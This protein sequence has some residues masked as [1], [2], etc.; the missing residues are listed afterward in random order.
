M[1]NGILPLQGTEEAAIRKH[2]EAAWPAKPPKEGKASL[3]WDT[4]SGASL[5]Y[6]R[7]LLL[8]PVRR[9]CSSLGFICRWR[10]R[11][12][13]VRVRDPAFYVRSCPV[14]WRGVTFYFPSPSAVASATRRTAAHA[15]SK[16]VAREERTSPCRRGKGRKEAFCL[17]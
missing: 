8:L 3:N 5:L 4:T 10:L 16:P 9:S 11:I 6:P 15:Q 17:W 14:V 1:H 7:P 2:D 13:E 12:W